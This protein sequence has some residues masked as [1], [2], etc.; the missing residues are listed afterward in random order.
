[1][2]GWA[3]LLRRLP[4][5]P[6]PRLVSHPA[7]TVPKST[8]RRKEGLDGPSSVWIIKDMANTNTNKTVYMVLT[9]AA[10]MP[11]SCWGTYVRVGLVEVDPA[12]I[13]AG[14]KEPT[15]LSV[16]SRGV[17]RVVQAWERLF[18]GTSNRCAASR[19]EGKAL[20]LKARL[21]KERS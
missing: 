16:R 13:P 10:H 20:A 18:S 15:M 3:H 21:E 2:A 17:V 1:M 8:W 5:A 11:N 7:R 4:V 19:A 6:T 14:R 12:K 9:R